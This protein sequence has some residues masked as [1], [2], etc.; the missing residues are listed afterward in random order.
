[1]D[2]EVD[3]IKLKGLKIS[4]MI[5]SNQKEIRLAAIDN[6]LAD[7]GPILAAKFKKDHS[8]KKI[9]LDKTIDFLKENMKLIAVVS[10]VGGAFII[11]QALIEQ[12]AFNSDVLSVESLIERVPE[13]IRD[14]AVCTTFT[15]GVFS[16]MH[17]IR[18][19]TDQFSDAVKKHIPEKFL[20]KYP[21]VFQTSKKIEY[22]TAHELLTNVLL[23]YGID[24]SDLANAIGKDTPEMAWNS[25][26]LGKPN[27]A[28]NH[29]IDKLLKQ[30]NYFISDKDR[31]EHGM[32]IDGKR[33]SMNKKNPVKPNESLYLS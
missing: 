23:E 1:M 20:D 28:I 8:F 4:R 27:Q 7:I 29:V 12:A 25:S 24:S 17:G 13:V 31:K 33:N 16:L 26:N 6:L 14:S 2:T 32:A 10:I 21:K 5:S 19:Y 15:G 9:T 30:N 22:S 18:R 3:L 11:D